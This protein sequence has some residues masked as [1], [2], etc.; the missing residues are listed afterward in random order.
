MSRIKVDLR[1]AYV[2]TT[3]AMT[4]RRL[5]LGRH[6][7][8]RPRTARAVGAKGPATTAQRKRPRA[9][10]GALVALGV[11]KPGEI[12]ELRDYRQNKIEGCDAAVAERGLVYQGK[13]YSMS[14]LARILFKRQGYVTKAIRG[15]L[16]WFTKDGLSIKELWDTHGE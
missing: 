9:D 16:F 1:I 4:L 13:R 8:V 6:S 14:K 15:P 3:P 12:L 5:L 10:I 2:E 11:L 7:E